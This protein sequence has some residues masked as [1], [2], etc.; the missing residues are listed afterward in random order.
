LVWNLLVF[1][2]A[3]LTYRRLKL[4]LPAGVVGLL[5]LAVYAFGRFWLS[6][7]REDSLL[8]GLRQAQWASLAMILA[9]FVLSAAWLTWARR[10]RGDAELPA[11]STAAQG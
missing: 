10:G 1:A 9:A 4:R 3:L 11:A 7:L 2:L 5:W 8:Y 6:F